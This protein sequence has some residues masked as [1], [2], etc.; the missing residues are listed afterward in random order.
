MW[1]LKKRDQKFFC[2]LGSDMSVI[3]SHFCEKYAPLMF[4]R[5]L[6]ISRQWVDVTTLCAGREGMDKRIADFAW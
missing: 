5:T 1:T 6:V 2:P 4:L 3:E